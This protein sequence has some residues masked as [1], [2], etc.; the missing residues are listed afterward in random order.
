MKKSRLLY[1]I[2]TLLFVALSAVVLSRTD[3]SNNVAL[4]KGIQIILI[5]FLI[6]IS[7]GCTL[8]IR[9]QYSKK[10]YSYAIIMNL[11]LLIF[12][13]VNILRQINLLI[14]N[15]HILNIVNIYNNTLKSFSYFAMLTLPCIIILAIYSIIT[16]LVLIKKEGFAPQK[17]LGIIL[18][19]L[20][21]LGLGGSQAIYYITTKILVGT[22]KQFVK[23]ALDICIN[24][25]LSYFYTLI[26]ATLYC[27]VRA[28]KHIPKYDKDFI[29]ILG[30]KI[31]SDG[32][33]TPLLKGRVD[34]AIE[35]GNKQL[36]NKKKQIIYVPSGGKGHDEALSEAEAIKKYLIEKG[37]DKKNIIVENKSTNT[38]E[39]MKYSKEKI[40]AVNKDAK[41]SF[42]TTSYHVFRSGV[43]ATK[44]GIDCEGMG[45]KTKW[46]FYTNAL[47]REFIANIV[48]EKKSHLALIIIINLFL[49]GLIA[50]GRY[51]NFLWIT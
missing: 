10:K 15:W 7:I 48:Q 51:F 41:I 34:K 40:D 20:A 28:A 39:N 12:I 25:T 36:A 46:Y 33:L 42:A 30:S 18:G 47:I 26:I 22:D 43:I 23:Y 45:S 24:A 44:Q 32:T 13:N 11:G 1:L 17:L 3:L 29:I 38:I 16:N 9:K 49:I 4:S 27:N 35:F 21:L 6:R 2:T 50:I 19:V 14:C 31:N 8:Y 5:L 37:I